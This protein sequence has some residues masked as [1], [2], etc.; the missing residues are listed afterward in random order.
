MKR[1]DVWIAAVLL[2]AAAAWI[3]PRWFGGGAEA[4]AAYA[5]IEVNGMR[6]DT[7]R[8]AEGPQDIEIRTE[9]GRNV[10]RVS[11]GGIAMVEADCPDQLCIGFGRIHRPHETI[12]CLPN[13]IFVEIVGTGGDGGDV[14]AAVR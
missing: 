8:L 7:V 6:H 10:L 3:I 13:R 4:S 2:T 11:R 5:V 1:R 14:D 12:V 9:R